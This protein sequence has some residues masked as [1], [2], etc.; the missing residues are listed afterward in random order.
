MKRMMQFFFGLG[1][2]NSVLIPIGFMGPG[3]DWPGV[4][5][6]GLALASFVILGAIYHVDERARA[7]FMKTLSTF[8]LSCPHEQDV[9]E[10]I[11]KI[12]TQIMRHEPLVRIS[13]QI[14]FLHGDMVGRGL[15]P[16]DYVENPE[17]DV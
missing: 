10:R 13:H 4:F 15:I 3:P 17:V 1:V 2:G 9:Q 16:P 7:Q 14:G 6:G 12:E 5:A 8:R 11:D